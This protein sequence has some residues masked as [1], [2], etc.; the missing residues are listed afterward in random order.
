MKIDDIKKRE[1]STIE[2]R[3]FACA[4]VRH[5]KV[6][7]TPMWDLL[8]ERSRKAVE[9]A[10]GYDEN[11][12]HG[13]SQMNAAIDAAW[14]V[15]VEIVDAKADR[16][17]AGFDRL[18]RAEAAHSAASTKGWWNVWNVMQLIG[19]LQGLTDDAV[20]DETGAAI[21]ALA[22]RYYWQSETADWGDG[23]MADTLTVRRGNRK[24]TIYMSYPNNNRWHALG[25]RAPAFIHPDDLG[26]HVSIDEAKR[27]AETWLQEK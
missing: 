16:E 2:H 6:H 27:A 19:H 10:E 8:D 24:A 12:S 22:A 20:D 23:G 26:L 18:C 17:L 14:Q 1:G 9:L 15:F 4:I 11:A 5:I 21:E 7:D 13:H 25:Y 3:R